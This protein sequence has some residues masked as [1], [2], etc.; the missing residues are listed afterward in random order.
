MMDTLRSAERR[1]LAIGSLVLAAI[2]VLAL[3]VFSQLMF[4]GIQIDLTEQSIY[5]LTQGTRD[6]LKAVKEP[7]TLRFFV[8][9]ELVEQSPAL[10]NYAKSVQELLERYVEL[11]NQNL[12]LEILYPEPFSP[13]EDRAVGFGL[14]GVPL[15]QAGNLGYF[16]LAG[17]NT[18]DDLDVIPFFTLSRE[19]FLE[20]DL[21]RLIQ[22]LDKPKN[23]KI[24]IITSLPMMNDP[25]RR[26]RPW[27][28][29][30]QMRQFFD[31]ETVTME[32]PVPDD[33][34]VLM[35]VHPRDM[36]DT[37]RYYIDQYVLGGGKTM[38][39][40]D[41]FSEEATRGNAMQR[42]PPD[43][44]SDLDKLFK[45]WGLVF[46]KKKVLGDRDAAQRVSAGKDALGRQVITNYLAWLTFSGENLR[47]DDVIT[48]ELEKINVASTGFIDKA[49]G[50]E[51]KFEPLIQ[52]S[53]QSMVLAVSAVNKDPKPVRLLKNFKSAD[54]V[55]TVAARV[56]GKLKSAF[57]DGP[58]KDKT[59]E[60]IAKARRAK[61]E[62]VARPGPHLKESVRPVNMIVVADVDLLADSF[63][64]RVQ[65]F[66]GQKVVI[67][68]ANNGDFVIN[69]LDNL[70]GSNAL[71]S[72]RSRG[73]TSRP[74]H[75]VVALQKA[76]ELRYR[77]KEQTLLDRLKDV[78]DK[79]KS[80]QTKDKP[81]GAKGKA[82]I[83]SAEQKA[84][85]ENFRLQSLTT[86]KELRGVQLALRRDIDRLDGMLKLINIGLM[87]LLVIIF[88]I[89]LWLVR[90][91]VAERHRAA[92]VTA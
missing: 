17:T 23:K 30:E 86:R 9:R 20:Y 49:E 57:P 70:A 61:G 59:R 3:H 51:I 45:A 54:R 21:S 84:A 89:G 68:S 60:E 48:G 77:S 35:V 12:K 67:P 40:V 13:E 85:I 42:Q 18:T 31:V 46:D 37:D 7:I 1:T 76:A 52:S 80:L 62:E 36:D 91:R 19:R 6:V 90:R 29:I 34:D 47:R 92:A 15:T 44:G 4:R 24:G 2:L 74:F 33:I 22:N 65:D 73:V 50:A 83:L 56:S 69:A 32:D 78:E 41:P 10:N 53:K 72:L 11:S 82:A 26:Y 75:R 66:F 55:F 63:W 25:M 71:I 8:S 14:H 81:G 28:I 87:P 43:T 39:F 88:A 58:P 27:Q 64:V 79:L 5:T 38:I 16:G